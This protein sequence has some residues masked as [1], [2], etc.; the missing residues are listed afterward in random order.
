MPQ[1]F[2]NKSLMKRGSEFVIHCS[3]HKWVMNRVTTNQKNGILNK[4]DI[5]D[6]VMFKR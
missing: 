3:R 4:K 5:C 2:F 1:K 6:T